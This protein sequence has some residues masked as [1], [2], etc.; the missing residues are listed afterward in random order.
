MQL[1]A[2]TLV[3][4]SG[5]CTCFLYSCPFISMNDCHVTGLEER[6]TCAMPTCTSTKQYKLICKR[7]NVK[8]V[9]CAMAIPIVPKA[10][11]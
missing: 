6:A 1:R 5:K 11:S 9:Y 2:L 3:K 4:R 10:L 8:G 7:L